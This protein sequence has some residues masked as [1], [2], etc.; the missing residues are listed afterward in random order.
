MP[1]SNRY[2]PYKTVYVASGIGIVQT[3]S[4][5]IGYRPRY[6]KNLRLDSTIVR[7]HQKATGAKA[8]D[9]W[10]KIKLLGYVEVAGRNNQD[11]RTR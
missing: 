9:I 10:T 7:A 1:I 4:W 5:Q 6:G 2:G 8:P 11:S 3:D